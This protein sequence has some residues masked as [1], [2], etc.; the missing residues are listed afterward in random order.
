[1]V[2]QKDEDK[3]LCVELTDFNRQ[4]KNLGLRVPENQTS[5]HVSARPSQNCLFMYFF[6]FLSMRAD[7]SCRIGLQKPK[8]SVNALTLLSN[9]SNF[10]KNRKNGQLQSQILTFWGNDFRSLPYQASLGVIRCMKSTIK[11]KSIFKKYFFI[12]VHLK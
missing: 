7:I 10:Y 1:M 11:L 4:L 6:E 3:I 12:S 8:H 9:F 2:K 5:P